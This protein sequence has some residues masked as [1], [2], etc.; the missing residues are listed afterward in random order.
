MMRA[1]LY[2]VLL[3][4]IL[5]FTF[6]FAKSEESS[7]NPSDLKINHNYFIENKGQWPD[8]V[9]FLA[10]INGLNAWI[11]DKFIVYFFTNLRKMRANQK[12]NCSLL[13]RMT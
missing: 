11:T 10:K 4:V 1:L 7:F 3:K 13:K 12:M 8:E 6:L 9:K 2:S 5:P